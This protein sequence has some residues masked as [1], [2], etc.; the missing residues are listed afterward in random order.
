MGEAFRFQPNR[1]DGNGGS[2]WTHNII[3]YIWGGGAEYQPY[4]ATLLTALQS[5][6]VG[7]HHV[8]RLPVPN[9]KFRLPE[10]VNFG[11]LAIAYG[12]SYYWPN[13]EAVRLPHQLQTFNEIYPD[14]WRNLV[15]ATRVCSCRANPTCV[16]CFGTGMIT[17]DTPMTALGGD[18]R[19]PPTTAVAV[20]PSRYH[21]ALDR[22]I[23]EY[24]KLPRPPK[25]G[26]II[27]RILLLDQIRRLSARPEIHEDDGLMRDAKYILQYNFGLIHGRVRA[28]RFS[29]KRTINGCRCVIIPH[30]N[31]T[32]LDV[33]IF[34]DSPTAL[35]NHVNH[36]AFTA[37][38][39]FGCAIRQTV[40]RQFVPDMTSTEAPRPLK[41]KQRKPK[42]GKK[43]K[44]KRN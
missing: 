18:L 1:I 22:C 9:D 36:E 44:K 2:P 7:I 16:R 30:A 32:P 23:I 14:Y 21:Q 24:S 43:Y 31:G 26:R 41:V 5:L 17:P 11:R 10:G 34:A 4:E 3:A 25:G 33:E 29:A 20:T 13:L 15:P 8:T 40:Q 27:E 35:E 39:D 19:P 38:V 6:R 28:Q 42:R 12:L 37:F